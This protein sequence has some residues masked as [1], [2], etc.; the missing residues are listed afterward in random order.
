MAW[1]RSA[2][3]ALLSALPPPPLLLLVML[4]LPPPPLP[5]LPPPL[6]LPLRRR[7]ADAMKVRRNDDDDDD[8]D[9][10]DDDKDGAAATEVVTKIG[11]REIAN[12]RAMRQG[13]LFSPSC[14]SS[15]DF[16]NGRASGF[17]SPFS[18]AGKKKT[19]V[20]WWG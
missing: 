13:I 12:G 7:G 16:P 2:V 20:E 15:A 1:A 17:D 3:P 8:D 14:F 11:L 5:P 19:N 10:A 6:P 9:D 4:S 18:T